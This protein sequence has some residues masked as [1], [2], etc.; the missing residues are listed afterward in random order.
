MH[1]P[2]TRLTQLLV[3]SLVLMTGCTSLVPHERKQQVAIESA[4]KLSIESQTQLTKQVENAPPP[5]TVTSS[6]A[7]N[8]VSVVVL[9]TNTKTQA[10]QSSGQIARSQDY[11]FGSVA[12]SIPMGVKLILIAIGASML[13]A[14]IWYVRR[15]S[16]AANAA[17][18]AADSALARQIDKLTSSATLETDPSKIAHLSNLRAD[19]EKERGKLNAQ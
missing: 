5:V 8:T 11:D 3:L 17:F 7:S 12:S 1:K 15:S 4:G 19:L 2:I 16:A 6:G 10:T 18:S 9:P 13:L 14:V